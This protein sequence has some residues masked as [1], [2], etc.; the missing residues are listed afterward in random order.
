MLGY[1]VYNVGVSVRVN[2]GVRIMVRVRVRRIKVIG[3]RVSVS[4]RDFWRAREENNEKSL[5]C[6]TELVLIFFSI[7]QTIPYYFIVEYNVFY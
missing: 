5:P 3:V 4:F 7:I 6:S 1:L 2:V